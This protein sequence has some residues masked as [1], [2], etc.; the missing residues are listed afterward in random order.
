MSSTKTFFH[1]N[2]K[3]KSIY[4]FIGTRQQRFPGELD[5]YL[6]AQ[7]KWYYSTDKHIFN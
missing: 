1:L 3:T 4:S 7:F 6:S 2:C 5:F